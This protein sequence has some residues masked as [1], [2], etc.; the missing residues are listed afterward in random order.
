MILTQYGKPS[1]NY[2]KKKKRDPGNQS[3]LNPRLAMNNE[4]DP[5]LRQQFQ[6][7]ETKIGDL[8]DCPDPDPS[9]GTKTN[10]EIATAEYALRFHRGG[11]LA[12]W[13]KT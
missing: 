1:N 8:N 10:T 4:Y 12:A 5:D 11:S 6:E 2:E 7:F 9:S 13:N 3:G